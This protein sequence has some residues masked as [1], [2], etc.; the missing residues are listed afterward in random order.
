MNIDLSDFDDRHAAYI[1]QLAKELDAIYAAV[2]RQAVKY[3][4]SVN[5][6][7]SKGEIF[8]FDRFPKLK[9]RVKQLF[10]DMQ[11][12]IFVL[13]QNGI[14]EEWHLSA[15]KN[16]YL[17]EELL[18][19]TS[20]T[21]DE[22]SAFKS[23]NLEALAT[24]QRRKMNGLGLSDRVWNLTDSFRAELELALDVGIGE[25]RSASQISRD[26]RG[27]LN[28]PDKLFRRVRDKH[29]NLKLSK[30]ASAYHPGQGVYRS[31]YKNALRLARTEV[32][33][34]Y[35]AADHERWQDEWFVIGIRI[36]LSNN[37]TLNGKPFHDICDLL[38]GDYPKAFKFTGWHP[39]CRCY[40][41]SILCTD[42]DF[43]EYLKQNRE[44][45]DMS[46]FRFKG[47]VKE[48]PKA[49]RDWMGDN[50]GRVE[51]MKQ[52]PYF[53]SDNE[54]LIN[55][56]RKYV[57]KTKFKT[58]EEKEAIQKAWDERKVINF[59]IMQLEQAIGIKAG[60]PMTYEDANKGKENPN[61]HLNDS[62]KVNCQTCV[63]VHLLRRRGLDVEA[64]PNIDGSA[65]KL[66]DKQNVAWDKNLFM[67]L[68]GT[69]VVFSWARTWAFKNGIKRM[70]E[71]LISKFVNENAKEDGIYEIYCAW[72][73]KHAHVFCAERRNGKIRFFDPQSGSEN[74]EYY[75]SRMKGMSVGILRI[76]DKL[77]NPK[78]AGLFIKRQ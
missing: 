43:E 28:Q 5:F 40:V 75:F 44:G 30:A 31:S 29:G 3:G 67:N 13:V 54:G 57:G 58:D 62:Y 61:F 69:D 17:L 48:L 22:I 47:E 15:D 16:D 18:A 8:N 73:K 68:D 71:S 55:P 11:S 14:S 66:M 52:K 9:K 20:L 6:D 7:A 60:N 72:K 21:K 63:P 56:K 1:G 46:G 50:A 49:F 38:E 35:R 42:E 78:A 2:I 19:S 37:H 74:I 27:Y 70:N 4:L 39:Q 64:A 23:R 26:I 33:M 12:Q 76:D 36:H 51:R 24:F 77:V 32:N 10:A 25:G 41:T 59:N 34:A 45:K 65:Y 53:I